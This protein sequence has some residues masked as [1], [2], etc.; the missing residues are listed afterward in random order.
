[1]ENTS[2][3]RNDLALQA[4]TQPIAS[5]AEQEQ[6]GPRF[7]QDCLMTGHEIVEPL[8]PISRPGRLHELN[9]KRSGAR[10]TRDP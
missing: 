1:V 10:D 6:V 4:S 9:E 5:L 2:G 3:R 7:V 8:S